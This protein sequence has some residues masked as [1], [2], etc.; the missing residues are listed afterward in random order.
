MRRKRY[1]EDMVDENYESGNHPV[2][3]LIGLKA[4]KSTVYKDDDLLKEDERYIY[5]YLFT[6]IHTYINTIVFIN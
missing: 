4:P 2:W 6:C 3:S 1:P 5:T